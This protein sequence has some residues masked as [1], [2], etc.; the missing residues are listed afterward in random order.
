[1]SWRLSA[2][3]KLETKHERLPTLGVRGRDASVIAPTSGH[4]LKSI[5]TVVYMLSHNL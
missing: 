1:M 2:G 3:G 4:Y 5:L